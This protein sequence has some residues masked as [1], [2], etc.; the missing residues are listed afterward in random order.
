MLNRWL[1]FLVGCLLFVAS[2][3]G[4]GSDKDKDVNKNKDKPKAADKAE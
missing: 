1:A 3:L 4:C 2:G